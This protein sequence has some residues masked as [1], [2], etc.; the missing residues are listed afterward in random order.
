MI[1]INNFIL[2]KK[3][4]SFYG[5][6]VNI[7]WQENVLDK[8][9][10]SATRYVVY[11]VITI[12]FSLVTFF[13]V[14]GKERRIIEV[15]QNVLRDYLLVLREEVDNPKF[16]YFCHPTVKGPCGDLRW[17]PTTPFFFVTQRLKVS[18]DDRQSSRPLPF[19]VTQ[20]SGSL[21]NY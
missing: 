5:Q 16:F 4:H 2:L 11:D 15:A 8:N 20:R 10:V 9:N 7:L 21:C 3:N 18:F 12:V 13:V 1:M 6:I 19:F 17:S 14:G